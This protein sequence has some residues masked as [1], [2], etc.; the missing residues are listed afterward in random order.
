MNYSKKLPLFVSLLVCFFVSETLFAQ[1]YSSER[2]IKGDGNV[3]KESREVG[4]FSSLDVS[5]VF[6]VY[7]S[8]GSSHSL[9]VEADANLMP[10]IDIDKSGNTLRVS[11][12]KGSKINKWTEMN[13]YITMREVEDITLSGMV[14]LN[15]ETRI[16]GDE[17]TLSHSGMGST[18][19][20]LMCNK[21][22]AAVSGMAKLNLSGQSNQVFLDN[23]GMG[24]IEA[25]SL[26]ATRLKIDN[27]GMGNAEVYATTAIDIS[28]SGMGKVTYTGGAE[29]TSL[30]SSGMSSK[31]KKK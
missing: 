23:A 27:S 17:I 10:F 28:S 7:V 2:G 5:G 24:N 15:G 3:I 4:T 21:F 13:L 25:T 1:K 31:V 9:E 6:T 26:K 19:L 11:T 18:N 22:E 12:Q 16:Q 29:V 14:S 30:H 8:Q 20:D